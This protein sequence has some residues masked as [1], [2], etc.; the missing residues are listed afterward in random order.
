MLTALALVACGHIAPGDTVRDA[1]TAIEVGMKQCASPK[2]KIPPA[3][4]WYAQLFGDT[5]KVWL[6][7]HDEGLGRLEVSVSK[8]DGKATPCSVI[9]G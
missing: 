3:E 7:P 5:W 2:F 4:N 8:R 6:G 9:I 1:K